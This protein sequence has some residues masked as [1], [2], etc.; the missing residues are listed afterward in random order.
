[1][2]NF[3]EIRLISFEE[4]REILTNIKMQPLNEKKLVN[5]FNDKYLVKKYDF[6]LLYKNC[7]NINT[8]DFKTK[9]KIIKVFASGESCFYKI[10]K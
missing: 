2:T 3:N 1:M 8:I 6:L 7:K 9:I 4:D 10:N 5:I